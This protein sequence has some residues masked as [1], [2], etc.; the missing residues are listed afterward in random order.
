MK[1]KDPLEEATLQELPYNPAIKAA[2]KAILC[3]PRV[4]ATS[5]IEL[6][7]VEN[8]RASKLWLTILRSRGENVFLSTAKYEANCNPVY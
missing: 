7:Q 6:V 4:Y 1:Y 8:E 2:W 5:S 3:I